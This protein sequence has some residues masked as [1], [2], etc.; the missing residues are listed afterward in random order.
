MGLSSP[1]TLNEFDIPRIAIFREQ[2]QSDQVI[3]GESKADE[4]TSSE[5]E[6]ERVTEEA[7]GKTI[8]FGILETGANFQSR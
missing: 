1:T 6:K 2:S 7:S 4:P 8:V 5:N 3:K